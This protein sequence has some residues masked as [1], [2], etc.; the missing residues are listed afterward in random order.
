MSSTCARVCQ[1][2]GLCS[3]VVPCTARQPAP[4]CTLAA[5][6]HSRAANTHLPA[7]T[8]LHTP[9]TLKEPASPAGHSQGVDGVSISADGRTALSWAADKAARCW[10]LASGQCRATLAHATGIVKALLAPWLAAGGHHYRGF[11]GHRLGCWLRTAPLPAQGGSGCSLVMAVLSRTAQL[12]CAVLSS[13]NEFAPA[14]CCRLCSP[15]ILLS[16][17]RSTSDQ[18]S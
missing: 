4:S 7:W 2:L 3:P 1:H 9:V 13:H 16:H 8:M 10:D 18:R 12:G 5:W 11:P 14:C 6:S 15:F 17:A